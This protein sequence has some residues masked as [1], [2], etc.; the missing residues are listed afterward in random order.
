[1]FQTANELLAAVHAENIA[2]QKR[3][4]NRVNVR[5]T[6]SELEQLLFV[7]D[8]YGTTMTG[9]L[10]HGIGFL[11]EIC[12]DELRENSNSESV[13]EGAAMPRAE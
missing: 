8:C 9:A 10:V 13:V 2:N 4:R 6:D 12:E 11:A 5:L 1:M 7:A 3:R